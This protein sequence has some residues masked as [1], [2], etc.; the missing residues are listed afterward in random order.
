MTELSPLREIELE[1]HRLA[2]A[3]AQKAAS[4][5]TDPYFREAVMK[6]AVSNF[7]WTLYHSHSSDPLSLEALRDELI[8]QGA[9]VGRVIT[10][11]EKTAK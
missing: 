4:L 3:Y 11:D 6:V 10:P 5:A 9:A 2:E 8:E 7:V 1:L